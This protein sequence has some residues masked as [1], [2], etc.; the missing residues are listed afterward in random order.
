VMR[1]DLEETPE[2]LGEAVQTIL[3][4]EGHEDAYER[5]RALTRG[6]Q[7]TLEQFRALFDDLDVPESVR[8]ELRALTPAGYTGYADALVDDLGANETPTISEV[9]ETGLGSV[10]ENEPE[11]AVRALAAA[12]E[13]RDDAADTGGRR[14][15]VAAG[16]VLLAHV[17]IGVLD[18]T[19][20]ELSELAEAVEAE[21]GNLSAAVLA[22]Y[23]GCLGDQ[24]ALAPEAVRPE[25]DPGDDDF[26]SASLEALVAA[27]LLERVVERSSESNETDS[28]DEQNEDDTDDDRGRPDLS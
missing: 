3:R 19:V 23:Q 5:V 2:I 20:V 10:L 28:P 1:E 26:D 15:A 6:Q 17:E 9:Y 25:A 4:R 8:E 16:V 21:Q 22:L 24:L 12:W 11:E 18:T 27:G 14:D 13:A 7:V